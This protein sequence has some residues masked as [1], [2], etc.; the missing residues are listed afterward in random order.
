MLQ[1]HSYV[2]PR[3]SHSEPG[4]SLESSGGSGAAAVSL[5]I[6]PLPWGSILQAAA[7]QKTFAF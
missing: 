7:G 4:T 2:K 6:F 1:L 5:H 3:G